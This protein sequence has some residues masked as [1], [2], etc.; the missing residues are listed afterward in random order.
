MTT[1]RL[2]Y[3]RDNDEMIRR[4]RQARKAGNVTTLEVRETVLDEEV[5]REIVDLLLE[6]PVQ[7][8]Q[9]DDCGAYLHQQASRMAMALSK[10]K[11]LRLSEPTFLSQFFLDKLLLASSSSTTTKLS[12]LRIQDNLQADQVEAL[13]RGL[14]WNTSVETL[15]LSRSRIVDIS[16]LARGLTQNSGLKCLKLRSLHLNDTQVM[17]I[18]NALSQ[19]PTIQ[20][21]DLSFNYCRRLESLSSL[22]KEPSN[23]RELL[24]GYQFL[25]QSS[26]VDISGFIN[27]LGTN[28]TLTSLSL[29]RNKLNDMDAKQLAMA[30][31]ENSTLQSINLRENK[32]SDKGIVTLAM[33]IRKNTG[34]QKLYLAKNP[35]SEKGTESLLVCVKEK[36]DLIHVELSQNHPVADLVRYYAILNMGGRRLVFQSPPLAIWP[37]VIERINKIDLVDENSSFS[38]DVNNHKLDVLHFLLQGP[39]LFEGILAG[40][41]KV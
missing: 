26:T 18:A 31:R 9:L 21:L 28:S 39:V 19:N 40:R 35:F 3:G 12:N 10:V 30:L 5:I 15:D 32:F 41:G 36:M 22:T 14:Q 1:V 37:L 8:V 27:T 4:L 29:P 20:S 38:S 23:L 7:T 34:L 13:A 33:G 25:W 11:N 2:Y 24:V 6:N 17:G 16:P